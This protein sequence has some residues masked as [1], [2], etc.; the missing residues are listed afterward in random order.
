MSKLAPPKAPIRGMTFWLQTGTHWAM[1]VNHT[2]RQ[3]NSRSFYVASAGRVTRRL[4][5]EWDQWLAERFAEGILHL[6]FQPITPFPTL[7]PEPTTMPDLTI[8]LHARDQRFLRAASEV[9]KRYTTT[10]TESDDDTATFRI[11]GGD[12]AY[13]LYLQLTQMGYT[14]WYDNGRNAD[15]RNLQGMKRGV[16]ESVCLLILQESPKHSEKNVKDGCPG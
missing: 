4:L 5:C 2:I 3:V 16:R 11:T 1:G 9:L 7:T 6:N 12:Q 15:H 14:V 8:D 10:R 13:N